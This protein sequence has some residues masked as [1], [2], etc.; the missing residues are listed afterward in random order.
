MPGNQLSMYCVTVNFN[1]YTSTEIANDCSSI[2]LRL[3]MMKIII[4][5]PYLPQHGKE[6][7]NHVTFERY[8]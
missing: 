2:L 4:V 3:G 6:L 7:S 8:G 1:G 5:E